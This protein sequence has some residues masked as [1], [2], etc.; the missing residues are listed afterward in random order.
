MF[1]NRQHFITIKD[2]IHRRNAIINQELDAIGPIISGA[3][4]D[5]KLSVKD[6]QDALGPT[7]Q[8]KN[9]DSL[10]SLARVLAV[11]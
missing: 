2:L 3:A 1:G 6:E 8:S 9:D 4:E 5:V 7:L 10:P 11:V